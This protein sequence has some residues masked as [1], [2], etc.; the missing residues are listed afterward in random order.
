MVALPTMFGPA[1]SL[2][3]ALDRPVEAL[4]ARRQ[5]CFACGW[6]V[7]PWQ[8]KARV[9]GLP[10]HH[11]CAFILLS[12]RVRNRRTIASDAGLVPDELVTS[13]ETAHQAET[14]GIAAG[15][16]A[17]SVIHPVDC[18]TVPDRPPA[19]TSASARGASSS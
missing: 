13:C 18:R 12:S 10:A 1:V 7:R 3:R 14:I 17:G 19:P 2:T 6:A 9:R 16:G 5:R 11:K 4:L 15:A 8:R